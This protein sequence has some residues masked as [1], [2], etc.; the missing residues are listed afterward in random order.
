MCCGSNTVVKQ[1]SPVQEKKGVIVKVPAVIPAAETDGFVFAHEKV[2]DKSIVLNG[3]Q[4]E[5]GTVQL[6]GFDMTSYSREDS[7]LRGFFR[8]LKLSEP[9]AGS[10][11]TYNF[12]W[13]V[14]KTSH[15]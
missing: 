14:E 6:L 8:L 15:A 12:N 5:A 4:Y 10:L 9:A 7:C 2:N 1:T 13:I 11:P 3:V